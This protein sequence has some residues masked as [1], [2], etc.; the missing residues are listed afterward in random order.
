MK[1]YIEIFAKLKN[2]NK[3]LSFGLYQ[4]NQTAD[5]KIRELISKHIIEP[6]INGKTFY[7]KKVVFL[8]V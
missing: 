7:N 4:N 2:Q 3:V 5:E 1:R 8:D 6:S